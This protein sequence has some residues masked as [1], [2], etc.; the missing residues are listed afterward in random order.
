MTTNI[1]LSWV[2]LAV[3]ITATVFSHYWVWGV[4]FIF[5]SVQSWVTGSVFLIASIERRSDPV[6]YFT[7]TAM[8]FFFGV[9]ELAYALL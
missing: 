6:L 4:L 7:I 9:W 5:W 3:L 1:R 8:W 2:V